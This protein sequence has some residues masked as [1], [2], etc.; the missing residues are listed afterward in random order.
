MARL[1]VEAPS[2]HV[3]RERLLRA[4]PDTAP[5][6]VAVSGPAGFGKS[7]LAASWAGVL[8]TDGWRTVLVSQRGRDLRGAIAHALGVAADSAWGALEA[9]LWARPTLLV[10]DDLEQ[11]ECADQLEALLGGV[12]GLL[13]L[14]T[15]RP[16]ASAGLVAAALHGRGMTLGPDDLAFDEHEAA[17]LF[18]DPAVA[19]AA[20]A[21]TG[22]WPLLLSYAAA[23]GG[24]LPD[25]AVTA[26]ARSSLSRAAW[27]RLLVQAAVPDAAANAGG[28][29]QRDAV[30]EL[31]EAGLVE[32]EAGSVRL[33][34]AVACALLRALGGEVR[35]AVATA[36]PWLSE[37]QRCVAHEATADLAALGAQLDNA[38]TPLERDDPQALLRWHDLAGGTASATRRV[39]VGNAL[40]AVGRRQ[41][42]I[43]ALLETARDPGVEP[44]VRL[45]ALGDACYFL[46]EEPGDRP[47]A[48]ALVAAADDLLTLGSPERRGR[49]LSTVSVVDFRDGDYLAAKRTVQRALDEMPGGTRHRYAPL[50]NLAVLDWNLTG[51]I[52]RRIALQREGLEICR[53]EYPDH[54]VGVCRDLAQLCLY[55]GRVDEARA[56]LAEAVRYGAARPLMLHDV[57]SLRAQLDGD[58]DE[59]A[60]LAR[61]A[62]TLSDRGMGDAIVSRYVAELAR[63]GRTREAIE[64]AAGAEVG[65]LT[66][67][68]A[69]LA[70]AA[71]GE[72]DAAVRLL[73]QDGDEP[74]ER[75]YRLARAAALFR[76]T[77]DTRHLQALCDLTT[78]G[79]RILPYFVPLA[80]LPGDRPDLALHYPLRSVVLS[81]WREAVALR[82]GEL[83]PLRV[84]TLGSVRVEV[85]GEPFEP[86]GRQRDLLALLVLGLGRRAIAAAL[87][88]EADEGKAR[89]NLNVQLNQLRRVVEPWGVRTYLH[90]DGLHPCESDVTGLRRALA[91]RDGELVAELYVGPFA[92]GSEVEQV[93]EARRAFEREVSDVIIEASAALPPARGAALLRRLLEFDRLNEEAVQRLLTLLVASGRHGEAL[94]HYRRFEADLAAE[95]GLEPRSETSRIV[96]RGAGA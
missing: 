21:E 42:G 80:E 3:E 72:V 54:A 78:A 7:D 32:V 68:A 17:S 56:Y 50:I 87:W 75:E 90:E 74:V 51:D 41:E 59:L 76:V 18:D 48:R 19:S 84:T 88:P 12:E 20:L 31:E 73:G 4:L 37:H 15:R 13:L 40:C 39:R 58:V 36:L 95:L 14:V 52:E 27:R 86:L 45:T 62:V 91:A 83:P 26:A 5:F 63:R 6:V 55:L 67:V 10:V 29:E 65:S 35:A 61:L 79:A 1:D 94:R 60:D 47:R 34:P 30:V 82:L 46:A 64:A 9:G 33:A 25:Q 85:M 81:R 70:H 22:G 77:R 66:A 44:D 2:R 16:L 23:T 93:V 38:A 57:G 96:G 43:A 11:Q 24:P 71:V 92:Q 69:A 89:N 53:S 8:A 49:F 28:H